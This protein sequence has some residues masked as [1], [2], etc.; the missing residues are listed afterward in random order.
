MDTEL[1]SEILGAELVILLI[2]VICVIC[3]AYSLM[4][5]TRQTHIGH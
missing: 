4:S 3:G 2:S 5:T 1:R